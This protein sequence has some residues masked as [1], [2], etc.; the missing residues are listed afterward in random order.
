MIY[1]IDVVHPLRGE[2]RLPTGA[3]GFEAGACYWPFLPRRPSIFLSISVSGRF[4]MMFPNAIGSVRSPGDD[5]GGGVLDIEGKPL[6]WG[7]LRPEFEEVEEP[8]E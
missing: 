7:G 3:L 5:L 2:R 1:A 4:S 8:G 6:S